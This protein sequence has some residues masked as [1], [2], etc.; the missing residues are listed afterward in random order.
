[1]Y[2]P[3]RNGSSRGRQGGRP[4]ARLVGMMKEKVTL[5][6]GKRGGGWPRLVLLNSGAMVWASLPVITRVSFG[7]TAVS[8]HRS[9]RGGQTAGEGGSDVARLRGQVTV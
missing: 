6:G 3:A 7:S 2:S 4:Q 8:L 1:M 5:I 9:L